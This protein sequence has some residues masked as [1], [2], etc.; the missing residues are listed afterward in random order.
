MLFN[1]FGTFHFSLWMF[2]IFI[3]YTLVCPF[4]FLLAKSFFFPHIFCLP[5]QESSWNIF[6]IDSI[7]CSVFDVRNSFS[8]WD[9]P[10]FCTNKTKMK[11]RKIEKDDWMNVIDQ[12]FKWNIAW[13]TYI[14]SY[15]CELCC[16]LLIN[17]NNNFFR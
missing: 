14:I 13:R 6:S 8:K 11:Q 17:T 12:K 7:Y 2:G 3:W 5:L 10:K 1:N 9:Y 15:M 4:L 16:N